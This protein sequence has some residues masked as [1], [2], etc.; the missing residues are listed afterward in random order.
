M[1]RRKGVG[2][3]AGKKLLEKAETIGEKLE[4]VRKAY[5]ERFEG[6]DWEAILLENARLLY[7]GQRPDNLFEW[8]WMDDDLKLKEKESESES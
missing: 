6:E 7:M 1:L 4:L 3:A 8:S 5:E 2:P